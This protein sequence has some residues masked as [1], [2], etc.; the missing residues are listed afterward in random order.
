MSWFILYMMYLI[1]MIVVYRSLSRH[2]TEPYAGMLLYYFI[3]SAAFPIV[4]LLA[5]LILEGLNKKGRLSTGLMNTK[6]ICS[7]K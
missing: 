6:I 2:V 1:I 5:S 7:K 4:G 3:L